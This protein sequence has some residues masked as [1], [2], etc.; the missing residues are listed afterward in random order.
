[1]AGDAVGYQSLLER[2]VTEPK[3]PPPRTRPPWI[4][5]EVFKRALEAQ[6]QKE[7]EARDRFPDGKPF[8]IP[9]REFE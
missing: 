9:Y 4:D 7:R 6:R 1:M 3:T 2:E 8:P 5:P